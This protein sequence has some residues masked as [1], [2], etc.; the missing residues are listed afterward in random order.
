MLLLL[1][2]ILAELLFIAPD[3][4]S[5]PKSFLSSLLHLVL[6]LPVEFYKLH[7]SN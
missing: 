5:L 7:Q 6:G 2:A 1:L 3:P 4:D